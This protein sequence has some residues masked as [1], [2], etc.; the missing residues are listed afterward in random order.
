MTREDELALARDQ[1]SMLAE[2]VARLMDIVSVRS[3]SGGDVRPAE[4]KMEVLEG[5]MWK[6]HRRHSRLR[7]QTAAANESDI[8][9]RVH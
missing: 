1:V 3:A 5:L 2:Q 4:D 9:A 7:A 8:D 6:L